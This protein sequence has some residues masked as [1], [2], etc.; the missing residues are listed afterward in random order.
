MTDTTNIVP[1]WLEFHDLQVRRTFWEGDTHTVE[2]SFGTVY[3]EPITHYGYRVGS[4]RFANAVVIGTIR[5][6]ENSDKKESWQ[7]TEDEEPWLWNGSIQAGDET[8][9]MIPIPGVFREIPDIRTQFIYPGDQVE[10]RSRSVE[11]ILTGL[12]DGTK[13]AWTPM[14]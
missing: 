3:D 1:V 11:V 7:W 4:I 9:A 8:P 12:Y 10:I 6:E 2:F 5:T 13:P 14:R